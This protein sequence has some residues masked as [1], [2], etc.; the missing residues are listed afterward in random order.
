ME[1]RVTMPDLIIQNARVIDGSGA[2]PFFADIAVA[3]G[4]IAHIEPAP[5]SVKKAGTDRA[6]AKTIDGSGLV[7]SPGFIDIHTHS[8][9]SLLLE[10]TADSRVSQG[11]TT[12]VTGNCGGSP[13]PVLDSGQDAFMEYMTDLGKHYKRHLPD[14]AWVFKTLDDFY[15]RL[16]ARGTAVNVAPL[17]GHST[18]RAN[19][20]GYADRVPDQTE[21]QRMRQL[22]RQELEKGAFGLSS[23]LIYHPG[24]FARSPELAELTAEVAAFS[25]M[26]STHMRSEGTFLFE[27][28]DEALAVARESGVSLEISHLKC[29]TPAMWGKAPLVLEKI[30][31]A[32]QEGIQV[33]FDQYPYTAYGTGLIEIFPP[34]AKE[35]GAKQMMEILNSPKTR[36]KVRADMTT[37]S[38]GWENPMEGLDWSQAR[39]MGYTLPENQA[40][41]GLTIQALAEVLGLEP[42]EAVFQVFCREKGGLG[43]IV[44][45]MSEQDLITILKDPFGMIGSDGRSVS[46]LG[47]SRKSPVHPRFYGTFPRILG[48]YVREKQ[49]ISLEQAVHKMTGLP[50]EKIGLKDRGL[51]KKGLAADLVLFDPD[52]VRDRADFDHPHEVSQGIVHV[53]VNGKMVIENKKHTGALPGKRLVRDS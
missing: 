47:P 16:F 35:Y 30:H 44:F 22:L 6:P 37:P 20:M 33:H 15:D 11:V 25:G 36:E 5:S 17:V 28:V 52:T 1:K 10:P 34:W 19:V 8:D 3:G 48:K 7:V 14:R 40:L 32:R 2:E 51:I 42:V 38:R 21:M 24:A 18:L 23:G 53:M 50:A 45:A 49:I 43:M 41:N 31:Q 9:F 12:E 29:E 39:I 46:P 27:A 13:A 26:Y 4:I